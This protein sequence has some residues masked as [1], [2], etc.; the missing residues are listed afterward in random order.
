MSGPRNAI[1]DI[2]GCTQRVA[3][4]LIALILPAWL[5]HGGRDDARDARTEPAVGDRTEH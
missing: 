4:K 2:V 1:G 3:A 5:A